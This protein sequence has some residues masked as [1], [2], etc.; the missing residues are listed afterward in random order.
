MIWDGEN[1]D[2]LLRRFQDRDTEMCVLKQRMELL[3]KLPGN[4]PVDEEDVRSSAVDIDVDDLTPGSPPERD[5][6]LR[7]TA[8]ELNNR[9]MLKARLAR[10]CRSQQQ[11]SAK[12]KCLLLDS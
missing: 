4:V 10:M 3:L 11:V 12:Y 2:D 9:E 1:P 6:L 7:H 5:D 8:K